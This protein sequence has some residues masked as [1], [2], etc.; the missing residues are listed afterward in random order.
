MQNPFEVWI[1]IGEKDRRPGAVPRPFVWSAFRDHPSRPDGRLIRSKEC[2]TVFSRPQI[3]WLIAS[4][5]EK[6]SASMSLWR[7]CESAS[8]PGLVG[9]NSHTGRFTN[10]QVSEENAEAQHLYPGPVRFSGLAMYSPI[11]SIAHASRRQ[12]RVSHP[13]FLPGFGDHYL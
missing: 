9:H 13:T 4:S 10:T 1:A 2:P 5:T 12:G 7:P 8:M 6:R 3:P 11:C